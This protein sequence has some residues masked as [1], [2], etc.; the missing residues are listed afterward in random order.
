MPLT[1]RP[2]S[3]EEASTNLADT[4]AKCFSKSTSYTMKPEI[5]M[6]DVVTQHTT[7]FNVTTTIIKIDND[8]QP[9]PTVT[10]I[11]MIGKYIATKTQTPIPTLP[12]MPPNLAYISLKLKQDISIF[13]PPTL[14]KSYNSAR[15]IKEK[16]ATTQ[17]RFSYSNCLSRFK[18][19]KFVFLQTE[20]EP[21]WK[22]P[23]YKIMSLEDKARFEA[24]SIDTCKRPTVEEFV[25]N[26]IFHNCCTFALEVSCIFLG[27]HALFFGY[28]S[29]ALW[30][31]IK[32][33]NELEK[34]YV[35]LHPRCLRTFFFSS[36]VVS[37]GH[38]KP[39]MAS[40]AMAPSL[41]TT[42]LALPSLRLDIVVSATMRVN[43]GGLKNVIKECKEIF[44]IEK[45][46]YF[47]FF[48]VGLH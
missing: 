29:V 21:P 31:E 15:F 12:S 14:H 17:V 48:C 32:K 33:E 42:K 19:P 28:L 20:P 38:L 41:C 1:F 44:T 10:Q 5:I 37:Y 13:Y 7:T 26:F 45:I 40:T 18:P 2:P 4:R 36:T 34:L 23:E 47:V 35:L 46:I 27:D 24:R 3:F 8:A 9:S 43:V 6:K 30:N 16:L 22:P 25:N 39:N 11:P